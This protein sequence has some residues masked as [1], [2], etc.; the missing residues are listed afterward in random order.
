M[1]EAVEGVTKSLEE[2]IKYYKLAAEKAC[3]HAQAA[4]ERLQLSI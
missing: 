1:Y 4:L 2:V 3:V